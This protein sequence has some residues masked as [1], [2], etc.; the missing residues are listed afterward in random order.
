MI[1]DTSAVLAILFDEPD[2]ERFARALQTADP[3]RMSA[4]SYLEAGITLERQGAPGA[5]EVLVRFLASSGIAIEPV[6]AEH[7][8][9]AHSAF[10]SFGKG[11]HPAALNF[12]DCLSYALARATDEPLLFKGNDFART[13]IVSALG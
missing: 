2:A 3:C 9:I 13:D 6:T 1:V 7:A 11:R 8:R 10:G 5:E 4:A 12:G